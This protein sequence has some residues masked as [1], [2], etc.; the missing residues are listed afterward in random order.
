MT[1][2]AYSQKKIWAIEAYMTPSEA[3]VVYNLF[4]SWDSDRALGLPVACSIEDN[5]LFSQV[6]SSVVISTPPSFSEAGPAY[7][8]VNIG[9]TEV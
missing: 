5:T 1:G 8:Y 9:L 4:E 2:P 6:V 7:F 3:E